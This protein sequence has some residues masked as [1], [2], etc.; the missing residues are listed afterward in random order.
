MVVVPLY[1]HKEFVDYPCMT[2]MW[3]RLAT[4]FS[5]LLRLRIRP[6]IQYCDFDFTKSQPAVVLPFRHYNTLYIC[7]GAHCN[8]T[9]NMTHSRYYYIISI[10]SRCALYLIYAYTFYF[11]FFH[12]H[13][14][15]IVIIVVVSPGPYYTCDFPIGN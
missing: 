8:H 11:I 5:L 12:A 9:H 13:L 3:R 6:L 7:I 2:S 10:Y 15:R 1:S 4:T 14:F